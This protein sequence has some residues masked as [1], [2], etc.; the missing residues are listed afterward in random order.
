M[1]YLTLSICYIGVTKTFNTNGEP[2]NLDPL[3]EKR[4]INLLGISRLH[5]SGD[6]IVS[7]IETNGSKHLLLG[8][9]HHVHHFSSENNVVNSSLKTN[10]LARNLKINKPPAKDFA[11]VTS[12]TVTPEVE[13]GMY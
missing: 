10:L 1:F 2:E 12:E 8:V 6:E 5:D 11:K 7:Q 13:N 9:I 4:T 3:A